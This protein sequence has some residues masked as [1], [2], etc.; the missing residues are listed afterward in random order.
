MVSKGFIFTMFILVQH[1]TS[2]STSK[3]NIVRHQT[4]FLENVLVLTCLEKNPTITKL[5][6]CW[7]QICFIFTPYLREDEPNLTHIF[8]DGLVQPPNQLLN[9]FLLCCFFCPGLLWRIP[10]ATQHHREGPVRRRGWGHGR[11]RGESGR[12]GHGPHAGRR[13]SQVAGGW[14]LMMER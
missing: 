9:L 8:S 5:P 7:F 3:N 12:S 11:L 4:I 2:Q 1:C 14:Q 13:G 6:R 10:T